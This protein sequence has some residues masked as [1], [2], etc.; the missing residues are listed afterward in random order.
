[1]SAAPNVIAPA[2]PLVTVFSDKTGARITAARPMDFAEIERVIRAVPPVT[3]KDAL[4]LLKMAR[5]GDKRSA[6]NALRHDDNVLEVTGIIAEYD[7]EWV[8]MSAAADALSA[9]G[10]AALLYTSPNHQIVN[11]P[12][13]FGGPRWRVLTTLAC[14]LAGAV[15]ELRAA[16]RHWC[17]VLNAVLGGVLS[18]ESF[19][20]SQ[21]YYFGRLAGRADPEIIT[22][23]GTCLDQMNEP[24]A[25]MFPAGPVEPRGATASTGR[26]DNAELR[27]AF[28]T[29]QGRYTSM[30]SFAAR[31]A[32]SG[33]GAPDIEAALHGLLDL[34]PNSTINGD[35]IDLRTRCAPLA[36]SAFGKF[37]QGRQWQP[38]YLDREHHDQDDHVDREQRDHE[39]HDQDQQPVSV[40]DFYSY[41][42]DRAYI[43]T[44]T[45]EL[46]RLASVN[47]RCPP[48]LGPDGAAVTVKRKKKKRDGSEVVEDVAVLPSQWLDDH[49]PIEQM[50]WAPGESMVIRGR[51]VADGGWITA[52]T[53]RRFNLY[54]PP[55][56]WHGDPKL[57]GR[58]LDHIRLV[59]PED[60]EHIIRW[61][62]HRVQRPGEKINHALV[63]GG[64]QGIG[65]DTLLEPVKHAVGPWNFAEVSPLAAARTVQ[66]LC[67]V[68]HPAR[69]RGAGLRRV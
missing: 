46:W 47:A 19:T 11:P 35:G 7:G 66:W 68:R 37:S 22:L 21:S 15:P 33:M 1:M 61:L 28:I 44:P 27:Q 54:R 43:F 51:L 63:L 13:S 45:R 52:L 32:G 20:L 56:P 62:A 58:W 67:Q 53:A 48:P 23:S 55:L 49:H 12:K 25:P 40:S 39:L 4:A 57:A 5:F 6:K 41:L 24:P 10:I 38:E 36:N 17:G 60:G 30:R 8:P 18:V 59:Y 29:E 31:W 14:P 42:P 34:C 9:A 64:E 2:L 50:T 65:K 26:K 16:H 69:Q 3:E